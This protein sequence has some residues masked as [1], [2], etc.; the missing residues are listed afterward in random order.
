[1]CG[2]VGYVGGAGNSLTRV[3]TAMSALVY[4]APDS[5]GVATF[6]DPWEPVRALK[7]VG[8]VDR[9]A[10]ALLHRSLYGGHS[11]ALAAIWFDAG[12]EADL[13]P[14]QRRVLALEGFTPED[15]EPY[16]NGE[17]TPPFFD[18]L[19]DLDPSKQQV[20]RPGTPGRPA[21]LPH[22]TIRSR[23]GLA[24]LVD[25]FALHYDLS[26]TITQ[27]LVRKA[28]LD[29]LRHLDPPMG[30]GFSD[31]QIKS[32]FDMVFERILQH[33][34]P[35]RRSRLDYPASSTAASLHKLLWKTLIGT[36]V[37][38]PPDFDRDG[39]RCV[40]RLLD[41]A[42]V[43][44]RLWE[45]EPRRD[46][47]QALFRELI[48]APA[49]AGSSWRVAYCAERGA[50]V[51]G[52]AAAAV[53]EFLR[54]RLL[55]SAPTSL[56]QDT[57]T[58]AWQPGTT[59]P[60]ALRFFSAPILAHG[61]YALQSAVTQKN[62]HPFFDRDRQR[63][64]VLNGQ[65]SPAV[66]NEIKDYLRLAGYGFRSENSAEYMSLL[67]GHY[68]ACFQKD[69]DR[70]EAVTAHTQAGVDHISPASQ[71]I[72]FKVWHELRDKG[73]EDL[74]EKAFVEAT[75]QLARD[76]G[77]IAVAG[78]S[79]HSPGRMYVASHNRPVFIVQRPE[80]DDFM[81]VSD[82]N[83]AL[84]LFPQKLIREKS[85]QL[86]AAREAFARERR[87][88]RGRGASP[89]ELRALEQRHNAIREQILSPF[90]VKV[91]ALEG[92]ENLAIIHTYRL[93]S[94][95]HRRVAFKS[96][97]GELLEDP[98]PLE[99]TIHPLQGRKD[100]DRSFFESHLSEIPDRL[101]TIFRF[102]APDGRPEL[103]HIP[104]R[105]R[106]LEKK[107]GG[108]LRNLERLFLVGM[109][110]SYHVGGMATEIFQEVD[111]S[112]HVH[113][114][115]PMEIEDPSAVFEPDRDLVIFMSWSGT[116]ADVIECAKACL[117]Q[118]V[119]IL[120]LT[121]KPFSDLAL[122]TAKS[123]GVLPVMSGEEVTV[124]AVKSPLCMLHG[125]TL[126]ALWLA[127]TRESG[128]DP[129]EYLRVVEQLPEAVR[130]VLE[131][132]ETLAF[133]KAMARFYSGSHAAFVVDRLA[134]GSP[135]AEIALKLEETTWRTVARAV[136][137]HHLPLRAM[138]GKP[139]EHLVW[140]QATRS[141]CLKAARTC[142]KE[143]FLADIAFMATAC[144][145]PDDQELKALC[146]DRVH[147]LPELPETF[148][149][150][151]DL[152]FAYLFAYHFGRAQGRRE[153]DFP[154]NLAKSVTT[155]RAR[156]ETRR[157]R[158]RHWTR[159]KEA[160][161]ADAD[162]SEAARRLRSPSRLEETST[163]D[164]ERS[165]LEALRSAAAALLRNPWEQVVEEANLSLETM[166]S[167][168]EEDSDI[169]A[170]ILL[171]PS[172]PPGLSAATAAA[173]MW[174]RLLGRAFRIVSSHELHLTR[175]QTDDFLIPVS[176]SPPCP[177]L[178]HQLQE[179]DTSNIVWIAAGPFE[180]LA[181]CPYK[182]LPTRRFRQDGWVACYLLLLL[183]LHKV[184]E[185]VRPE[186]ARILM[187]AFRAGAAGLERLLNRPALRQEVS[188][189]MEANRSY[190]SA[191]L[192]GSGASPV[193]GW[194]AAFDRT[195]SLTLAFHPYGE[196][197]HGSLVTVDPRSELKYIR[198]ESR[199]RMVARYGESAVSSWEAMFL[200]G[201]T[202]DD[203]LA[204]PDPSGLTVPVRPFYDE[205]WYLPVLRPDYD[206][207]EDN[208]I[209]LDAT[210]AHTLPA[211]LDELNSYGCRA[212]RIVLLTQGAFL[213]GSVGKA[214]LA[215]PIS[216]LLTLPSPDTESPARP[217][218]D[219]VVPLCTHALAAV[220]AAERCRL[221]QSSLDGE[222]WSE[223][224]L[225]A[226]GP[227]RLIV[228]DKQ[229]DL[230][231]LTHHLI[232]SLRNLAPV[233]DRVHTMTTRRVRKVLEERD[234]KDLA[235]A[236][237][238]ASPAE[239]LAHFRMQAKRDAPFFL[240]AE[241]RDE[242]WEGSPP[243]PAAKGHWDTPLWVEAHG[244]PWRVLAHGVVG[245]G[246]GTNG[247][248]LLLI[249][250]LN[251][252]PGRLVFLAVSYKDWSAEGDL[253]SAI[254]QTC[255]ALGKDAV[256]TDFQS[257]RYMKI[258]SRFNSLMFPEGVSWNDRFLLSVPRA[259]LF[260]DRSRVVADFIAEQIR[261][262]LMLVPHSADRPRLFLRQ[263]EVFFR[264]TC[265]AAE[266]R[267]GPLPWWESFLRFLK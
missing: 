240:I 49:L 174:R 150:Y 7:A 107:F 118:R 66:E 37:T 42:I 231:C 91:Y 20:L 232:T 131:G 22:H 178:V 163:F 60:S 148:Q 71:T 257:P 127:S 175:L 9:L 102:Y 161:R 160:A 265:G 45:D 154:R 89:G 159:I 230:P 146:G 164:Y 262:A 19:V 54:G 192:I 119:P 191:Y 130:S 224:L 189:V 211:A 134:S 50:N 126:F 142:M 92:P 105:I 136:D 149:V 266:A 255:K 220:L 31:E 124:S 245:M 64:I 33:R 261:S 125:L 83:A 251:D 190:A 200:G 198:M 16:L 172:D 247:Q 135:A 12:R 86:R 55:G 73:L 162:F 94:E 171:V 180:S 250:L 11:E 77:Q 166:C 179:A 74:D 24:Q 264:E 155:S 234:L 246:P 61:R 98:E 237:A 35:L 122:L 212:A 111:P 133:A 99:T 151:V 13:K 244:D 201:R 183:V 137:S 30:Q 26:P 225:R 158:S 5:T 196:S 44:E 209:F 129:D 108:R 82:V 68:F 199:D 76:G 123:M 53:L 170:Q 233:I 48:Q 104:L 109:G 195:R 207:A 18:S 188:N 101:E 88:L 75:R 260:V 184:V 70:F 256:T 219:P 213:R 115:S 10:E 47:V 229:A 202:V 59:G 8:P 215:Q 263:M 96:F 167:L 147:F 58:E 258:V 43:G 114:L 62:S 80:N 29:R 141:S 239:A 227:L 121:E 248:G 254:D 223:H 110:T 56:I 182:I 132:E 181:G 193:S 235:A 222:P 103:T 106:R 6:G 21:P 65:F 85:E 226:F 214:L 194:L 27:A 87:E 78:I 186:K 210:D 63:A 208:L 51:Y 40:F 267:P 241:S 168:L 206:P 84:G 259:R 36:R 152:P 177:T 25:T 249:P 38:I 173:Q 15:F 4:R 72:D 236:G 67:W 46:R 79:T 117:D 81:V 41:S 2:I 52:W 238:L 23:K 165:R 217:V 143:L 145:G 253:S 204:Q 39:V 185:A 197:A 139:S 203:F 3:L 128:L 176:G 138:G 113:V 228:Q 205:H 156:K 14:L 218:P 90:H 157:S 243:P 100:L 120:A 187:D 97:E 112:V 144:R 34:S 221:E 116:T 69:K 169:S 252:G 93:G 242:P 95:V 32:A 153:D 216:H 57:A 1:M 17:K 28:F 140:V